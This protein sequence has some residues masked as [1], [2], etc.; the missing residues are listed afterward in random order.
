MDDKESVG[1]HLARLISNL[2]PK[3]MD[4]LEAAARRQA[5]KRGDVLHARGMQL[6][7]FILLEGH[8]LHRRVVETGQVRAALIAGPGFLGGLRSV[9]DPSADALYELAALSDGV[10]ATW[11]PHLMRD[12]ALHDANLAVGLLDLAA[13]Y[14]VVLNV[15]LDE[16]SFETA[17]QR[18]AAILTRYGEEMFDTAHPIAR[19]ADLA[20]MIGTSR[21]LMYRT[22]RNLEDEGLV[23]RHRGGG[24]SI[25]DPKALAR[26]VE[27]AAPP[28]APAL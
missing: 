4:R 12:L 24:I 16:R 15:R 5:F 8:L 6:P 25:V 7:P 10:W 14:A 26:L 21:V 9:S 13:A 27:V 22:L 2:A 17:R 3:T 23:K 28:G 18:M 11:D 20:A 1:S 19:R